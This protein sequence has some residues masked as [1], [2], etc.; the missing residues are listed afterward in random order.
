MKKNVFA[1]IPNINRGQFAQF[2]GG[3]AKMVKQKGEIKVNVSFDYANGRTRPTDVHYEAIAR[4]GTKLKQSF[5]NPC[6]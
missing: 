1:Q 5:K 6:N 3:V 4:D 2:E